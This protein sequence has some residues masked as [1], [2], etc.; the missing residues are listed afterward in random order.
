MP[1]HFVNSQFF[2]VDFPALLIVVLASLLCSL[3]GNYLLLRKQAIM[4]DAISHS[5]LPGIV[6][7]VILSGSFGM[8]YVMSGALVSALIAVILV[9][10]F[11]HY[12]KI[13]RNAAIGTVFT[14]M[15]ASGVLLLETQ[16]GSRIHIDTQHV[17]YGA[18]ELTYWST[19]F[20]WDT[21]PTQIK[22]L[23]CVLILA[24]MF[25]GMSYKELKITTFDPSFAKLIGYKPQYYHLTLIILSAL[26]AVSCFEATGSILV[27]SLFICPPAAARIMSNKLTHQLMISTFIALT[28][29]VLGYIC[30]SFLPIWLGFEQ[31]VNTAA[32]IAVLLGLSV[33]LAIITSRNKHSSQT[34]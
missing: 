9:Y 4:V 20:E 3:L 8:I 30:A 6:T 34:V 7:G 32:T 10:I 13:D 14:A 22:T 19:P 18:L 31:T 2:I 26:A 28:C 27:I 1:D 15:F 23:S 12:V 21:M 29:S 5:V 16:L 33:I 17:L 25:I 24:I 11:E